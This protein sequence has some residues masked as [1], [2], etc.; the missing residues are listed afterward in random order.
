MFVGSIE[1]PLPYKGRLDPDGIAAHLTMMQRVRVVV[2]HPML[3]LI[4]HAVRTRA[5]LLR[6]L[7]GKQGSSSECSTQWPRHF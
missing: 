6:Y 7:D 1:E 3:V 2:I 5:A 4:S